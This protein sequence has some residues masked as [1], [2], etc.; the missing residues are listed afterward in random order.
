MGFNK[1]I[2]GHAFLIHLRNSRVTVT[3][4]MAGSDILGGFK[5]ADVRLG[6]TLIRRLPG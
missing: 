1:R 5:A 3:D 6:F 2:R 4:L